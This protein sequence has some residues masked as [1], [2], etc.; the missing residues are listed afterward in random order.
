MDLKS[1]FD[2]GLDTELRTW[3]SGFSEPNA[4]Y[5]A[6]PQLF[7]KLNTQHIMG[8]VEDQA[9][10]SGPVY[11]GSGTI[12][13]TGSVIA[14]PAIIADGVT[15]ASAVE[16]GERTYIGSGCSISH[17]ATTRNCLIMNR[18]KIGA[19][20]FVSDALVGMEC[21][22]GPRAILGTD[23]ISV[24]VNGTASSQFVVI[25]KRSRVGAGAILQHGVEVDE[26]ATVENGAIVLPT[27]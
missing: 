6:L 26:N 5:D 18:T 3:L 16:I 24:I 2:D 13:R 10:I 27:F 19:G 4:L 21:I 9:S 20:A 14:G 8:T 17:G 11:I 12:V 23:R 7:S 25:G 1:L 15:I 22:V